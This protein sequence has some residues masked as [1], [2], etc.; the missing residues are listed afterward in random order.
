MGSQIFYC[1]KLGAGHAVKSLNNYLGAAGTL[2]GFEAL[3]I[4]PLIGWLAPGAAR[5]LSTSSNSTPMT[6]RT[7]S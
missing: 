1:G 4:A 3:L 7:S 2:A 6:I 5:R